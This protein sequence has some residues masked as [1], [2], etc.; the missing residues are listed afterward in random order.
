MN[1]AGGAAQAGGSTP[2]GAS[3]GGAASA[4]S[5][6]TGGAASASSA[7]TGGA[8]P[9]NATRL[10]VVT[11]NAAFARRVYHLLKKTMN[12]APDVAVQRNHK[13]NKHRLY[14]VRVQGAF[15]FLPDERQA[16]RLQKLTEKRCCRK[17]ALRGAFLAGGSVTN[18]EKLY[19]LEICCKRIELAE[20]FAALM[21]GFGLNPKIT[22]RTDYCVIYLKDSGQIA[23]FLNITGAHCALMSLENTRIL[24][25]MRNDV[26]RVVNFETANLEKTVNAS[27][28]QI[29]NIIYIKDTI[30]YEALPAGLRDI[31][32]AREANRE[33]S[34][35]ELGA[36][37][38]PPL[39]KSGVNHRLRKLDEIA[40]KIRK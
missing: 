39:G 2:G 35:K 27:L 30:G 7:S 40:E 38:N 16:E 32:T 14:T 29:T 31:A 10:G 33:I 23:D 36:L 17:A 22:E 25:S 1:N 5:A 24:K 6:S 4:N 26:N 12:A 37:M 9:G 8:S 19:H 18:P 20:F 34:L 3:V 11:E 21:A 13:L 15:D 28:R